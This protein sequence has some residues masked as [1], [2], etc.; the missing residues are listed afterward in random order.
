MYLF[1][2]GHT[3]HRSRR[4]LATCTLLHVQAIEYRRISQLV[5]MYQYVP[6]KKQQGCMLFTLAGLSTT[7]DIQD[8][9]LQI[10][11]YFMAE[12]N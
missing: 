1:R 6:S 8:H 9:S 5:D 4:A 3:I 11:I 7:S 12:S 2:S 10:L